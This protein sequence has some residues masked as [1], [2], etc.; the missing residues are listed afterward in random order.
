MKWHKMLTIVLLISFLVG[1]GSF[2][3]S[4]VSAAAPVAPTLLYPVG[5]LSVGNS[6]LFQFRWTFVSGATNYTLQIDNENDFTSPVVVYNSTTNI[7]SMNMDFGIWYGRVKASNADGDS[8][9]SNILQFNVIP[10]VPIIVSPV[11]N[12]ILP[13]V[14]FVWRT[15]SAFNY[16]SEIQLSQVS[17][18]S[19]L[20]F[21]AEF[22]NSQAVYYGPYYEYRLSYTLPIG[23]YYWRVRT[24]AGTFTSSWVTQS[25]LIAIPP[26]VAPYII[27]PANNSTLTTRNVAINWNYIWNADR[28]RIEIFTSSQLI[29]DNIVFTNSYSF[30]GDDNTSYSFRV[31]AGNPVGWGPWS[32]WGQFKILLP[33]NTPTLVSPF[34]GAVLQNNNIVVL[35]WNSIP[36]AASYLVEISNTNTGAVQTFEV[37]APYTVLN[38]P[39]YWGNTYLWKIKAKNPSGESGWSNSWMFTIQ[40]NTPPVI[41]INLLSQ[42]TN[43]V[44]VTIPGTVIDPQPGSGV[45]VFTCNSEQVNF[46]SDGTFS[47]T[48][49]LSE[50]VNIFNF[51]AIDKAGNSSSQTVQ[52]ILD[53]T[54]PEID[55]TSPVA[56]VY[57]VSQGFTVVANI[58]IKGRVQDALLITLLINNQQVVV[59][60]GGYF[61]YKMNLNYGPNEVYLKAIDAAGN[62]S[63][64]TLAIYKTFNPVFIYTINNPK[65]KVQMINTMGQLDWDSVEIDPGRYTIPVIMKG[66]V[67]I[68]IRKTIELIGGTTEWGANEKKITIYVTDRGKTI[69]LWIGKSQAKIT[70]GYG[71]VSWVPIEKGDATVVPFIRNDR[72]YFPLRFVAEQLNANVEWN[73]VLQ[74]V[75]IEFP[76]VP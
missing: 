42:Y 30:V 49:A 40:E 74:Q 35:N 37:L 66:R 69:E 14:N 67:F 76:I 7:V 31:R 20:I 6:N 36:T 2:G 61:E 10:A 23:F 8:P 68:P 1:L 22:M 73:Q 32:G 50:G 63:E 34:N 33:P 57:P 16:A 58:T 17:D 55:I 13:N 60:S 5:D 52:V 9:W 39:G 12:C 27:S 21:S 46:G 64:K 48:K 4:S 56:P 70:D 29:V 38:F 71:N 72:S 45:N 25:F 62:V 65:M 3:I 24:W 15:Y 43:Q 41:T 11:D 53:T 51:I 26:N 28:Y 59:T 47:I 18:F 19:S 75:R 44:T 54:P